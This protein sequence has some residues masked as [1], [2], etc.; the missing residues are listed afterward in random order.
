MNH[1]GVDNGVDNDG[2]ELSLGVDCG[3]IRTGVSKA[4]DN[5]AVDGIDVLFDRF[6]L[7][8]AAAGV[9][10]TLMDVHWINKSN[11]NTVT[12]TSPNFGGFVLGI[13]NDDGGS[14]SSSNTTEACFSY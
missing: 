3:S 6:T 5:Y 9:S 11:D 13:S 10:S 4:G 1:D 14:A 2:Y 8:A 12:Y 7:S